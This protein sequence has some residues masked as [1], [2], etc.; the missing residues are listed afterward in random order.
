VFTT[1]NAPGVNGTVLWDINNKGVI[2]G[3][4]SDSRGNAGLLG[5]AHGFVANP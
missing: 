3:S 4:Y 5:Y 1:I 2:V